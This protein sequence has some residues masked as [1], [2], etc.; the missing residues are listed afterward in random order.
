LYP[1]GRWTARSDID[2]QGASKD[3][4]PAY[5]G[6]MVGHSEEKNIHSFQARKLYEVT[7]PQNWPYVDDRTIWSVHLDHSKLIFLLNQDFYEMK[8][9]LTQF[10][11]TE[12]SV[13]FTDSYLDNPVNI[14]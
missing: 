6:Y 5:S 12:A 13:N 4:L 1:A 9:M 2:V 14:C 3:D 11:I 10:T 7:S 8:Q